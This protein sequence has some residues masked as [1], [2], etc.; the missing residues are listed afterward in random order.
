MDY[1]D[2]QV[3]R[4]TLHRLLGHA[5]NL[6]TMADRDRWHSSGYRMKFHNRADAD[7]G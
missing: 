2:L 6:R 5:T 1:G 4:Y 3:A 7:A